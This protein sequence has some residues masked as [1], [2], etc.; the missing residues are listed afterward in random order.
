[1]NSTKRLSSIG[2]ISHYYFDSVDSINILK[3][4][5]LRQFTS[6][7]VLILVFIAFFY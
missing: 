5:I 3:D 6:I 1:M 7:W 4:V 2:S